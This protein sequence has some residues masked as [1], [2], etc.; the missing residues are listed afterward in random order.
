MDPRCGPKP[1][2]KRCTGATSAKILME[3]LQSYLE[4]KHRELRLL[5]GSLRAPL[6]LAEPRSVDEIIKTKFQLTAV[7]KA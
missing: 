3:T 1:A 5:N 4:R 7:L 6:S 2:L